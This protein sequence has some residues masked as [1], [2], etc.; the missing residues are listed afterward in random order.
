MLELELE[1]VEEELEMLLLDDGSSELADEEE[2]KDDDPV[3]PAVEVMFALLV[4][5]RDAVSLLD[6]DE[7]AVLLKVL[8]PEVELPVLLREL[9]LP[10]LLDGE[11]GPVLVDEEI[12][13]L[14]LLEELIV[15]ELDELALPVELALLIT[16]VIVAELLIEGL[17]EDD[18]DDRL[19]VEETLLRVPL[20]DVELDG[21]TIELDGGGHAGP[22][23]SVLVNVAVM[24]DVLV[25]NLLVY[26]FKMI[27]DLAYRAEQCD[28]RRSDTK[29]RLAGACTPVV[30]CVARA[31]SRGRNCAE[32]SRC[33]R[34]GRRYHSQ[35]ICTFCSIHQTSSHRD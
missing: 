12:V 20:E 29:F 35:S 27:S 13:P 5:E 23:V 24:Y 26:G 22:V 28:R 18:S 21:M 15:T 19:L 32:D 4:D 7:V 10:V 11:D 33:D 8:L 2:G 3:V 6:T 16:E 1:T 14:V 34:C 31:G 17:P 30:P 25:C 9:E